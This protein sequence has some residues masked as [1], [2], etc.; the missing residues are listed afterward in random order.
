MDYIL[1]DQYSAPE[2]LDW[3]SEKPLMMADSWVCFDGFRDI[4]ITEE[5]PVEKNG[6]ITFGT[7]NNPYKYTPKCIAAWSAV[8]RE[9]ED[10]QF[11]LVRPEADSTILRSMLQKEFGKNG[12]GPERINFF[13]NY[14]RPEPHFHYYNLI[15]MSLDTFPL[16]GGTTTCD[17]MWMGC[18]VISLIGPG[19]HQRI[20]YA[21][22]EHAG[23]GELA[24]RSFE[25]YLG[26]AVMLANDVTS[27]REYRRNLRP[28]LLNSP[29]CQGERFARNFEAAI[30]GAYED[31]LKAQ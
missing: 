19:M 28:A 26:R 9:V 30:S 29:L 18:P 12:I 13:N 31:Y 20:S 1:V 24:C 5:R 7:L 22:L 4:P 8:M 11:L 6:F 16:T 2:N 23:C 3:L 17:A 10:S 25:E 27:L 14:H 21:L 15:D